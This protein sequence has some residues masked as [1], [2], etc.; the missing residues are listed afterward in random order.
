MFRRLVDDGRHN[1]CESGKVLKGGGP[2]S[3]RPIV[4]ETASCHAS[5][6]RWSPGSKSRAAV[7]VR[8]LLQIDAQ[9]WLSRAIILGFRGAWAISDAVHRDPRIDGPRS[10]CALAEAGKFIRK[11]VSC[12]W[13]CLRR[14]VACAVGTVA[15]FAYG[16]AIRRGNLHPAPYFLGAYGIWCDL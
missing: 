13:F 9:R 8:Q 12:S 6:V 7:A 11:A 1:F 4:F 5:A 3:V 10:R 15:M 16:D 14:P 2:G